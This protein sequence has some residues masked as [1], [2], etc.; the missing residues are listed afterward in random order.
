MIQIETPISKGLKLELSKLINKL[1]EG[2]YKVMTHDGGDTYMFLNHKSSNRA[3]TSVSWSDLC[4]NYIPRK[5][6]IDYLIIPTNNEF[7]IARFLIDYYNDMIENKNKEI[8]I[9]EDDSNPYALDG[10]H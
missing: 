6:G 5:L 10:S 8:I 7:N 1:A 3:A 9:S 2:E 4:I